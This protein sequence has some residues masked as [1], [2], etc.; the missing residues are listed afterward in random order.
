MVEKHQTYSSLCNYLIKEVKY[1]ANERIVYLTLPVLLTTFN[2][3]IDKKFIIPTYLT[4]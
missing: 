1:T 3:K 4:T 2:Y